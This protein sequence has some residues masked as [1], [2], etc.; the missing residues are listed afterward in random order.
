VRLRAAGFGVAHELGAPVGRIRHQLDDA[1]VDHV[2][3][4]LPHRLPGDPRTLG[5][6][7]GA[8]AAW[9]GQ[10]AE[11]RVVRGL[12]HVVALAMGRSHHVGLEGPVG[13]VDQ[14]DE[15]LAV[16]SLGGP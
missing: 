5:E 4:H 1:E 14:G 15:R 11:D 9:R 6:V 7:D 2:A 13:A 10:E 16:R 3:D 12:H 8:L